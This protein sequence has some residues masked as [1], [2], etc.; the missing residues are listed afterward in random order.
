MT[1][2]RHFRAAGERGTVPVTRLTPHTPAERQAILRE[3]AQ[4]DLGGVGAKG[5]AEP[6]N[7]G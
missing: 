2:V 5:A 6:R 4:V 3:L 7:R 1:S